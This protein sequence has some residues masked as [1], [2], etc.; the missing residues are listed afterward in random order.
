[1][2]GISKKINMY[3]LPYKCRNN[4]TFIL[5]RYNDGEESGKNIK[6]FPIIFLRGGVF[7]FI[8]VDI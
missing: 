2:C 1:M 8:V 3:M 7:F 6:L 5:H 4:N